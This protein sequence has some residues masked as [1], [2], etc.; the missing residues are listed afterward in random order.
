MEREEFLLARAGSLGASQFHDIVATTRSG[1]YAASRANRKA[2]LVVERLTGK[3]LPTFQSQAMADGIE[4]EPQA[5]AAYC[6]ANGV[7]VQEAG[8]IPHPTIAGTHAS[9]D[10]LTGPSGLVEVKCMQPAGHLA[11][12]QGGPAAIEPRYLT[13]MAWQMA[14]AD[15][16]WVD[17]VAFNPDFPPA[18]Q[19][20]VHRMRRD[21]KVIAE[22]EKAA[23][24]FLAEVDD[25]VA[26][27]RA[28]YALEAAA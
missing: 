20:I 22:L 26:I 10:S 8:I 24:V 12:L 14:C 3:P 18:M 23:R 9:P 15:R 6:F 1:G 16:D 19:L 11:L 7:D 21:D 2:V 25:T 17:F 4:R 13:Q 5:I 27:L 28:R